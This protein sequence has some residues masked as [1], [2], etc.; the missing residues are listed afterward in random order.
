M[1]MLHTAKGD[2]KAATPNVSKVRLADLNSDPGFAE[3]CEA[4][5]L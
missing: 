1:V 2:M 4:E 3:F 5:F